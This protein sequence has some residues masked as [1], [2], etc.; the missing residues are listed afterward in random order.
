MIFQVK[1]FYGKTA[2]FSVNK[3]TFVGNVRTLH[4]SSEVRESSLLVGG[5]RLTVRISSKEKSRLR[6]LCSYV[7]IRLNKNTAYSRKLDATSHV[8]VW[9]R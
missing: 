1:Q 3:A 5:R 4:R 8:A 9:H 7:A 6:V 2:F